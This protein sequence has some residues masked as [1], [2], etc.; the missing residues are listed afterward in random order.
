V[1]PRDGDMEVGKQTKKKKKKRGT[2]TQV[3]IA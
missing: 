1:I 2:L 3:Q